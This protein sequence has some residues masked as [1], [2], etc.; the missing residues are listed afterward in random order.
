MRNGPFGSA[1]AHFFCAALLA[2][3]ALAT[4]LS[5]PAPRPQQPP[6]QGDAQSSILV[7]FNFNVRD[8]HDHPVENLSASQIHISSDG[9]EQAIESLA[10]VRAQ[11]I[12]IVFLVQQSNSRRARPRGTVFYPELQPALDCFRRLLA[13]GASVQ[14]AEFDNEPKAEGGFSTAASDLFDS[15]Q[16]LARSE[17]GG[18]SA[19]FDSLAWASKQVAG[20]TGYRA[21]IA[22]TDGHDN[23]SKL[24]LSESV[25]EVQAAKASLYIV[26]LSHSETIVSDKLIHNETDILAELARRTAGESQLL[27][28]SSYGKRIFDRIAED[29]MTSYNV[30]FRFASPRP[31]TELPSLKVW[32]DGNHLKVFAPS[33][34]YAL[35]H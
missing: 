25:A 4:K 18:A 9:K 31:Q 22:S 32:V 11:P 34:D 30:S 1:S 19:L 6:Q 29:I 12:S 27:G 17:P 21:I 15:M 5:G 14:V 28:D 10:P 20:R 16:K 3:T 23:L 13:L 8:K 24:N 35:P 2:A 33:G 26:N 7:S